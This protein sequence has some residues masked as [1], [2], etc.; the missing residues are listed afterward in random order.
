MHNW[1]VSAVI[2]RYFTVY[3]PRQRPDMAIH[4]FLDAVRGGH[5]IT[6][7][8]TGEQVRDF[9][10]VEDVVTATIAAATADVPPGTALN[11]AGGS[12]L[13][14]NE[15]VALVEVTTGRHAD[16]ERLATQPGDVTAT[17]GSIERARRLLG[18]K[19]ATSMAEGLARQWDWQRRL[20]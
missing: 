1:Q 18:W 5:R 3:G 10:F 11:V 17:G 9:T 7:W 19:P 16:V 8:G 6:L 14:V 15:L 20:R 12:S 4:R 2:L 13:S